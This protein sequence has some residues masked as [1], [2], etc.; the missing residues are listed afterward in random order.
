MKH[1]VTQLEGK[2]ELV[3]VLSSVLGNY[4]LELE[5]RNYQAKEARCEPNTQFNLL[6]FSWTNDIDCNI[7][8]LVTNIDNNTNQ[9]ELEDR[10]WFMYFDGSK[11]QEGSGAG[12]IRIDPNKN[13]H[14]LSYRIE[15]EC[16][17][18]TVEYEAL[19]LGLEK[20]IELKVRNL[21]VFG[22]SEIVVRQV[23]NTIHC[24]YPHLKGYQL[25]V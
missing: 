1:N 17:N 20:A 16:T 24:L 19:V 13:K 22:D 21:K 8:N 10:F 23:R 6:Q 14:F 7:V 15:F 18:N 2:N 9:V 4:F 3:N 25:E 5:P 11:T 12:C